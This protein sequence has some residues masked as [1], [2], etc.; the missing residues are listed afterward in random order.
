MDSKPD[1]GRDR[2]SGSHLGLRGTRW[3]VPARLQP[4]QR[5]VRARHDVALSAGTR[6]ERREQALGEHL[7]SGT[8]PLD[9]SGHRGR[10][11]WRAGKARAGGAQ[12]RPPHGPSDPQ[13]S[14]QSHRGPGQGVLELTPVSRRAQHEQQ[15]G[16]VNGI[17][18]GRQRASQS[19]HA[20][21][22]RG[23]HPRPRALHSILCL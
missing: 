4:L 1:T 10:P 15:P 17:A 21:G 19:R 20:C 7:R 14:P 12:R 11:A 22:R 8:C 16:P 6:G 13:A 2:S 18:A 23:A 5:C 9:T 3:V